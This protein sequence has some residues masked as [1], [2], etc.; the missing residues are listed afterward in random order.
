MRYLEQANPQRQKDQDY[1][2]LGGGELLF[3]GYRVSAS[4]DETVLE[5]DSS[6]GY[7][8]L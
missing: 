3:S 2:G 1:Q 7:T 8:T 6:D 4:H 5:V